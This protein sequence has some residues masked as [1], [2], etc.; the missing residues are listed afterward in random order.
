MKEDKSQNLFDINKELFIKIFKE[1]DFDSLTFDS[2]IPVLVLFGAERCKV[3]KELQPILEVV[4][5][6]Y[7][8]KIKSYYVNVDENE[9]LKKRFR[10]RGIPTLLL[11]NHGELRE[12]IAGLK[13]QE[14]LIEFINNGLA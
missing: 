1:S 14:E 6:D 9:D 5:D 3:C 8:G 4:L 11:F 7:D 2:S 13:S 12:R 10:L